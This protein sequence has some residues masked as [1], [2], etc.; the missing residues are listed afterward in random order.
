[1]ILSLL[2][3]L[4][5]LLITIT[6]WL[7]YIKWQAR[8]KKVFTEKTN[9]LITGAAQGLGKMLAEKFASHHSHI[10]LICLDIAENLAP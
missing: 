9:I 5:P 6:L 10:N 4:S 1:M 3:Y 7:F 2:A 8:P